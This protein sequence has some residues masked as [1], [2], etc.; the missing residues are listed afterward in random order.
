MWF[1][2]G[3]EAMAC[4]EKVA[5]FNM[6]YFGKY[7]ITGPDAQAAVDWIFSNNMQKPAG[8]TTLI[9]AVMHDSGNVLIP[10]PIPIPDLGLL[11]LKKYG[12]D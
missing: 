3:A 9:T 4:R 6:S 11:H 12:G 2:I 8:K 10:I 1:Q 5:C 7:Y